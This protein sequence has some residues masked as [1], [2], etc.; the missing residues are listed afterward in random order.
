MKRY[1]I[2]VTGSLALCSCGETRMVMDGTMRL[3]GP[4][5][6]QT[7]IEGPSIQY[8][9]VYVSDAL[10]K[11]VDKN[12]TRSDWILAVFGTPNDQSEL[13][14]GSSI[15]KWSYR[16]SSQKISIVS[17]FGGS[18][19]DKPASAPRTVFAHMRD[20]VVVDIWHD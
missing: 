9:G 15:W 18:G 14:D 2:I 5:Q 16:P 20:D 17:V 11:R 10:I 3:E 4:V 1:A 8:E 6:I 7:S 13:S 19:D 12:K